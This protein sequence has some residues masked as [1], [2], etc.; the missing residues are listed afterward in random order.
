MS[1]PIGWRRALR[2]DDRRGV[3]EVVGSVLLL[4]MTVAV[5]S[6]I[7]IFVNSIQGPGDRTFVDLVPTLER[8]G[9]DSGVITI[10]H[11]GGQPLEADTTGIFVQVNASRYV[12][13]VT[14]GLTPD[15]GRWVTGQR[16]EFTVPS[17]NLPTGATVQVSVVDKSTNQLVLLAVVQRGVGTGGVFPIIGTGT[18]TPDGYAINDGTTLFGLRVVAVD[19]DYDLPDNGVRVD[20]SPLGCGYTTRTL[21]HVGFGV[22]ESPTLSNLSSC[23]AARKYTVNITATDSQNHTSFGTMQFEVRASGSSTPPGSS[24]TGPFG[25][26]FA[27]EFQAYE[28]FNETEWEANRY[29]GNGTRTFV[30]GETVVIVVASQ[31]IKN[32]GQRNE[33]N[34]YG[35][36]PLPIK[37]VVYGNSPYTDPVTATSSPSSLDAFEFEEFIAGFFVYTTSFT[38][39][40]ALVGLDGVQLSYGVYS[41]EMELRADNVPPPRN[42]FATSDE[43]TI[44]DAFGNIPD[45]PT[46]RFY[47]DSSLSVEASSFHWTDTVYATVTV[48]DTDSSVSFGDIQIMDY[49]GGIQVWARPGT[50]PVGSASVAN[51]TTYRFSVDLSNPNLD[52]WVFSTNAY[53]F[54]VREVTDANEEYALVEQ[55]VI[56]GPEWGLDVIVGI[57]EFTH[58][59][60]DSKTYAAFYANDLL[61]SRNVIESYQSLPSAQS[62]PW[63]GG[64][65]NDVTFNDFDGDGDL[66]AA[67]ALESSRVWLYRNTFGS[68]LKWER[69]EID[70]LGGVEVLSI[71]SGPL[72][73][74]ADPE[75]VAGTAGGEVWEY[76]NDGKYTP[77][78]IADLNTPINAIRIA[79]VTGDGY[80]D[81]VLATGDGN[82]KI[83]INNGFGVFGT[84]VVTDYVM[85]ADSAVQ[86]VVSG[87]YAATQTSN[88][89]YESI[90]EVNGTAE[91][92]DTYEPLDEFVPQYGIIE[93]GSYANTLANDGS[94]YEVIAE[95]FYN[96]PGPNDKWMVRNSSAGAQPG[97]MYAFGSIPSLGAGDSASLTIDAF[98]SEGTEPFEVRYKVGSGSPSSV[99]TYISQTSE[100]T[101][102]IPLTGFTGGELYIILQDSDISDNDGSSDAKQTKVSIDYLSVKI[103]RASGVTSRLE[104][105]W[106]S[107]TIGSGG[108]A[109]RA[110]IEAYR[111]TSADND[112]YDLEW[113]SSSTGPWS[114]L[115]EITATSD[116]DRFQ[117]AI[118]PNTVGGTSIYFRVVDTNHTANATTADTLRVDHLYV[119][120][121]VVVPNVDTISVGTGIADLDVGDIDAD[122][123]N[124]IVVAAGTN[125]IAYF[126]TNFTS[127]RTLAAGFTVATVDLGKIDSDDHLDIIAGGSTNVVYWI[128][129]TWTEVSITDLS[130]GS[131]GN[132]L[133]VA[134]ADVDSDLWDDVVVGT[135]TGQILWFRHVKGSS[136]SSQQIDDIESAVYCIALGDV[137]RGIILDYAN[138]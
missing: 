98:L 115:T 67:Y 111:T 31:Y 82:V 74:D 107:D 2:R 11:A 112:T 27:N 60:F 21:M 43:I 75:I 126:G 91:V 38:T 92:V 46:L 45:F 138:M 3:S 55:I 7:I 18:V 121:Y 44:T 85:A 57:D 133:S 70:Y 17:P 58:P 132:V 64:I 71:A 40:S 89:V 61:W 124:D 123:A 109:Y 114:F 1:R 24:G 66:D 28:I 50:S 32:L 62:P 73:R 136:W 26:V 83:Y 10:T 52:P 8:T 81:V 102:T 69:Y 76:T 19:Y 84:T 127:S 29:T 117:T 42:R 13:A 125:V 68:G 54:H 36:S 48:E 131:L 99:L 30:K 47:S 116:T 94:P 120:R 16:W 72:D 79:D 88:N 33:L 101:S 63:G 110:F 122:G 56:E 134:V 106:R 49:V 90:T 100:S 78:L 20:L 37:P 25:W 96:G 87:T 108:S 4:L 9:P 119:R 53:A 118:L 77:S 113:S 5:F 15:N 39:N 128:T 22:Y 14:D 86:G 135:D 12:L 129:G 80:N 59:V 23:V 35:S 6:G 93:S 105:K 41:V 65:F 95:E 103:T 97:H 104:H 130:V 51:A 137:D 34:I